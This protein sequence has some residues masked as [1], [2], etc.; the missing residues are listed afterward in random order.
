METIK[1]YNILSELGIEIYQFDIIKE[2]VLTVKYFKL[3]E[4]KM[5]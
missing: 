1:N 3:K 5:A 4:F 2:R